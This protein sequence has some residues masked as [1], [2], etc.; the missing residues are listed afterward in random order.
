MRY[1]FFSPL[2][3][4]V[5][6]LFVVAACEQPV[7]PSGDM[8][9]SIMANETQFSAAARMVR[10]EGRLSGAPDATITPAACTA[11]AGPSTPL[12]LEGWLEHLGRVTATVTACNTVVGFAYPTASVNQVGGGTIDAA[13][14]DLLY[15][16]HTGAVA[17]N[18]DCS[19]STTFSLDATITGGTGRFAGSTGSLTITGTQ[20]PSTCPAGSNPPAL[21]TKVGV[22]GEISTVGSNQDEHDH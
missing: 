21:F 11:P 3:L 2:T 22:Q 13:N 19:A 5:A 18:V 14:G 15:F 16:T 7:A 6:S 4:S 10:T 17:V 9:S 1:R 12:R 8:A 20:V